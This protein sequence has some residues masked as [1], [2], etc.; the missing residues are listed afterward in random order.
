MAGLLLVV[1]VASYARAR[2]GVLEL[3][4]TCAAGAG[5]FGGDAA[6]FPV[7]IVG[8][9]TTP[10]SYVLTS[11]LVVPDAN[12][13]AI[14]ITGTLHGVS[15]D[16]AGFAILGP[17]VCTGAP[18][19]CVGGG[20][21]RGIEAVGASVSGLR[22]HG[23][24]VRGMGS[25][26]LSLGDDCE[27]ERV[28]VVGNAGLGISGGAGCRIDRVIAAHNG[29]LG[30]NGGPGAS[31]T[32][33]AVYGNALSGVE[34]DAGTVRGVAAFQNGFAGILAGTFTVAVHNA[35]AENAV[36]GITCPE[37]CVI[38]GNSAY[39]NGGDG[40]SCTIGCAVQANAASYNGAFGLVLGGGGSSA[41]LS[42]TAVNNAVG[43]VD[44]GVSR[45]GNYCAGVA[46]PAPPNC[47]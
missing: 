46:V 2:D 15:I 16:L 45:G 14:R 35:A 9:I 28:S 41:Y 20:T 25:D 21:G 3:N 13:D 39:D 5:C 23:G 4:Q 36:D 24:H 30:I 12:T 26:G 40:I 33:S 37:G 32:R 42:N 47:P 18:A 10:R 22:V 6:G 7:E 34:S 19:T 8:G 27:V 44:G 11:D 1:A 43:A 31:I 17:A 38:R 29:S